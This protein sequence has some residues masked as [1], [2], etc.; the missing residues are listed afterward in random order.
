ME[1]N[2]DVLFEE[3][4]NSIENLSERL[5]ALEGTRRGVSET[6][7]RERVEIMRRMSRDERLSSLMEE[8]CE[9]TEEKG[10]TGRITSMGIFV[11][12]GHQSNWINSTETS[13]L[14]DVAENENVSRVLSSF[15]NRERLKI[16]VSLLKKPKS[17]AAIV[18][19]CA[20]GSTGQAY[21][22]IN[23]LTAA[24]V[25][26]TSGKR[27]EYYVRPEKVQDIIMILAAVDSLIDGE[28]VWDETKE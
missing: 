4:K 9:K 21:H 28:S 19:D 18:E 26:V 14:L 2:Y 25:V 1:N 27:G 11:S 16:L 24:N 5:S 10:D 7:K 3:I 8:M 6:E 17:V 22:H 12:S 15:A 13:K 20:L 23:A